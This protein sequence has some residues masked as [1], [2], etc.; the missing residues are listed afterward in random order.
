MPL[1][2]VIVPTFNRAGMLDKAVQSVLAQNFKNF[3]LIVVDDGSNDMTRE[4]MDGYR[5][6][7][8]Y[9]FKE[10]GGVASA[11]N[12]GLKKASGE[13]IAWLDDDDFFFPDK[14]GKQVEYFK[15]NPWAGLVYTGHMTVDSISSP[16][17]KSFYVPPHFRDCC[18]NREA[19]LNSCF[20]ANST[21]MMKKECFKHTGFYDEGL[22]HTED[23]E[24]WLRVAAFY[25]FGCV[26]E[27]MAG[28]RWH[29][30]QLSMMSD[31]KI[32]PELRKKAQELYRLHSCGEVK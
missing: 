6:Q 23:Y 14:L 11:R 5:G 20:F 10:N 8:R 19:L 28:Y 1:V 13:L 18:S 16:E 27:V 3:E 31:R 4:I 25:R 26:P 22:R 15:K 7:T 32:L 9:F 2:S 12:Y 29:G 24:M 17:R 30:R 21:V